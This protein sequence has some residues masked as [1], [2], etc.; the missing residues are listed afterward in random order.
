MIKKITNNL[1][2]T[3]ILTLLF[4][5]ILLFE[6]NEFLVTINYVIV[7]ILLII[8][9]IE[10]I[11]YIY[12][13]AYKENIYYGLVMGVICIWLALFFYLHYVNILLL[14]PIILSLYAFIVGLIAIIKFINI[15]SIVYI[16]T[17][18][19]S[20]ILGIALMF[21]PFFTLEIYIKVSGIYLI[22]SSIICLFEYIANKKTKKVKRKD[23]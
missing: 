23:D 22:Y 15:K 14:L 4:G 21:T 17:A 5:I 11:S 10:I 2:V 6:T 12:S 20:F 1:L 9:V 18:M 7:S 13:K 16:I 19:L 8:G 3:F